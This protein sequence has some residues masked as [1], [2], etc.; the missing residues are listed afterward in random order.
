MLDFE[1]MKVAIETEVN[2]LIDEG[3]NDLFLEGWA[4]GATFTLVVVASAMMN[5]VLIERDENVGIN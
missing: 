5:E 3:K 2:K 4:E 1:G